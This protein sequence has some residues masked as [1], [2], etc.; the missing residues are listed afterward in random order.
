MET[1]ILARIHFTNESMVVEI[2]ARVDLIELLSKISDK[3]III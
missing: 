2:I 3:V 1:Q